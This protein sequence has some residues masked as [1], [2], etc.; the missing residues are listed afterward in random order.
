M[1]KKNDYTKG[2][3]FV[4]R[5]DAFGGDP[6]ANWN[7]PV[8]TNAL[9]T[10]LATWLPI[11]DKNGQPLTATDPF[12][13]GPT[14]D[15]RTNP[16]TRGGR[17]AADEVGGTPYGRPEDMELGRLRNGREVSYFAATSERTIY[18]IEMLSGNKAIVRAA[19]SEAA[20]PKNLGFP[21]TTGTLDDPD[22]LAQDALGNIYVI[23]D[24]PNNSNIGGDIWFM[25]D[26]D[27]DGVAE[28]LDHFMSNQVDGSE[29][30][31][32]IFNPRKPTPSSSS[33]SCTRTARSSRTVSAMQSGSSTS[34]T[35]RRRRARAQRGWQPTCTDAHDYRFIDLLERAGRDERGGRNDRDGD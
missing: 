10:G 26:T 22:N 2:R 31:G 5:V 27:S 12:R 34:R 33:P 4:L 15:P 24:W 32:M 20:T 3:T 25:R 1:A 21:A 35:S 13:N 19:A 23:E 14:S 11:T 7:E 17:G 6:A 29:S 30:T 8:N 28:S 9:R 18:S 16:A